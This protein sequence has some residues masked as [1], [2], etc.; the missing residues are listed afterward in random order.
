[1]TEGPV[2]RGVPSD[3]TNA[4]RVSDGGVVPVGWAGPGHAFRVA[5]PETNE[6]VPLGE[7]GELQASGPAIAHYLGDAGR[8]SF[9]IDSK[10]R[11]WLKTGDQAKVNKQGCIFITGRY[12]DMLVYKIL[13]QIQWKHVDLTVFECHRIIRGGENISPTA[14]ETAIRRNPK[15][16][17]LD[18][19][20]VGLPDQIAGEVPVVVISCKDLNTDT[21]ELIRTLVATDMGTMYVPAEVL[22]LKQLGVT[23][24]PR[25]MSGKIQK[26]KLAGLVRKHLEEVELVETDGK[27]YDS[28]AALAAAVIE[29][30]ARATGQDISRIPLDAPIS[31]FADSIL[32][33]RVRGKIR[34]KTGRLLSITEMNSSSTISG[35]IELLKSKG[36]GNNPSPIT[37]V[38][39]KRKR[40]EPPKMEDMVHVAKD[41]SLFTATKELVSR[42]LATHGL[43]WDDVEAVFPCHDHL[44]VFQRII[45]PLGINT[46]LLAHKASKAVSHCA[47]WFL[48]TFMLTSIS[49]YEQPL[50]RHW[51][52]TV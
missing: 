34:A 42:T 31:T 40:A 49:N 16:A 25:T 20:V 1:M 10:G 2:I 27:S 43:E 39:R 36:V 5:D 46:G 45:D 17:R 41:R 6:T 14:I 12:K 19:Q 18:P 33:I 26:V 28:D 38:G 8:S 37:V 21:C 29:I 51:Q 44:N 30:W 52:T 23:D 15:L 48:K 3:K 7:L 35:Q 32:I 13:P 22:S 47:C 4:S 24:F 11:S 9:Y 50:R